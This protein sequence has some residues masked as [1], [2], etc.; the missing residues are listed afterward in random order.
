MPAGMHS[1][2]N[3][4]EAVR[5]TAKEIRSYSATASVLAMRGGDPGKN[6]HAYLP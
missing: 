4:L 6:I 3:L 1:Y 5:F 2:I